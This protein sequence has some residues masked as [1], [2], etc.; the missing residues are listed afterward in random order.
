MEWDTYTLPLSVPYRANAYA[1]RMLGVRFVLAVSACGSL[2][3]SFEPGNI[4]IPHQLL[5][6]HQTVARAHIF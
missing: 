6:F 4:V 1:L 2:R 5:R 3:E